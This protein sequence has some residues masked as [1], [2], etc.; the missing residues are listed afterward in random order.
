MNGFSLDLLS[1]TGSG[2]LKDHIDSLGDGPFQIVLASGNLTE[3]R[4]FLEG[5]DILLKEPPDFPGGLLID[6]V[7]RFGLRLVFIDQNRN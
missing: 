5:N 6:D 4:A 7:D 3:T 1:P 2:V